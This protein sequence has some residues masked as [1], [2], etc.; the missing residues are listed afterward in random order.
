MDDSYVSSAVEAVLGVPGQRTQP[1]DHVYSD[2]DHLVA[3]ALQSNDAFVTTDWKTILRFRKKLEAL[4]I[5]VLPPDEA[6]R[7]VEP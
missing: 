4:G 5:R 2:V 1:T 3:H 6:V 7:L